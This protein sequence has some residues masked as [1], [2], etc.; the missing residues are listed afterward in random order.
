MKGKNNRRLR[1]MTAIAVITVFMTTACGS[2]AGLSAV[3]A[4]SSTTARPVADA[5]VLRDSIS[6]AD[7]IGTDGYTGASITGD[8]I[9]DTKLMNLVATH[10]NAVTF[11]NELKPDCLF[12]YH[13]GSRTN[14]GTETI[15][16]TFADGTTDDSFVV[17]KLDYSRAERMLNRIMELN[18]VDPDHQIKVRGHVLVWHSQTPEWFF[19]ENWDASQPYVS[20]KVMDRRQEWYIAT[21]LQHF[22]GRNSKYKDMFYGWDVVNEAVSDVSGYR[23]D[24]EN[25]S[26]K[27]TD[28]THGSKSSWWKIYQSSDYIVN[29]FRYA[30]HYAPPSLEL[31]YN[32][33]N[34]CNPRKCQDIVT[35]LK[36]VKSHEKDADLPTR[37]SA[38]G[39]QGHYDTSEGSPDMIQFE[40]AS[41]AYAAVTG[42][43][44]ITEMDLKATG[45]YDGTEKTIRQEY[46]REAVRY[47]DIYTSVRK[48]EKEGVNFGAITFW[49]VIDGHSW[50]Q[51]F[52]NAGGGASG[53]HSQVPL[54]FDDAYQPKPAFYSFISGKDAS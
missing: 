36:K 5:S 26:D 52:C 53:K 35:L 28:A 54:L 8:E 16:F 29:A 24:T 4:K 11:G 2:G 21:V 31:Y 33:Y 25:G 48:L 1:M 40:T 9:S 3:T 19:H 30:N 50:L 44:Q 32:D 49:G 43:V 22:T 10:F 42:K 46:R 13:D 41:K 39:M 14:P 7:G 27:L 18:E 23:K 38:M 15:S 34:E 47:H 17:P 37:I 6:S 51:Y 45:S 12:G 20:A